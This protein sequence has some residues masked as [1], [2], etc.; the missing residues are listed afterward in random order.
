[1]KAISPGTAGKADLAHWQGM[2]NA[3]FGAHAKALITDPRKAEQFLARVGIALRYGATKGLPLASLYRA[4][5][6]HLPE[7]AHLARAIMLTN[8][9]LGEGAAL[10]IHVIAS[11]VTLV[12]RSLVPSLYALVR[13][14]RPTDDVSGLSVNAQTALSL[15][16]TMKQVTAGQV[17]E[18]IGVKKFDPKADPAYAALGEL[19]RT[20]LV[21]RGPF[22][23]PKA[24]IPYLSTEGYPYHLL[25]EA[26]SD[27][28]ASARRYSAEEAADEFLEG[29][30]SGAAFCAVRKLA[31]LFRLF[32][33]PAEI[34]ASVRRL[35]EAGRIRVV[36]RRAATIVVHGLATSVST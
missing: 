3:G 4:F 26:H 16:G 14:G 32:L 23:V 30:L 9:M 6:G 2:Q 19:T 35:A 29:Y 8:K 20:M 33:S 7:K 11:R 25:H 13:R 12:H 22:V 31:S 18:R 24:G 36:E 1:M 27:L 34:D 5:G 10:E 21:D 17:R 15:L 28:V